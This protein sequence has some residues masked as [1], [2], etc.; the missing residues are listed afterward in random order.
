[1]DNL[2]SYY[3]DNIQIVYSGRNDAKG[4]ATGVDARFSGELIEGLESWLAV[5]F[6]TTM[7]KNFL[8]DEGEPINAGYKRRP[9]DQRF[10]LNLFFQDHIPGFRPLRLPAPPY[11]SCR[12]AAACR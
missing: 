4:F 6:M 12:A 11:S 2:I 8:N 1:M 10:A 7:D 9:T 3:L 5:S